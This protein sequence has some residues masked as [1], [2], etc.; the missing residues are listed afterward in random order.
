MMTGSN[1]RLSLNVLNIYQKYKTTVQYGARTPRG[2]SRS[3]NYTAVPSPAGGMVRIVVIGVPIDE[4]SSD[5][6]K[7]WRIPSIPQLAD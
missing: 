2:A 6:S 5:K 1:R 7:T 4:S 3:M